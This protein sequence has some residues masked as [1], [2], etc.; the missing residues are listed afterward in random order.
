MWFV[1]ILLCKDKS[2]YTGITNNLKK[3]FSEH[4]AGKG[5][6]YTRS[7]KPLKIIYSEQ[8]ANQSEALKR[9]SEIKSWK[10]EKKIKLLNLNYS[11]PKI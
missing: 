1:Y 7:H 6:R 8:L 4:K 11:I 9:E 3:R 2:L 5:G 10:R